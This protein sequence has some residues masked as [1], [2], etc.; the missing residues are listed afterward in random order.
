MISI[1][2]EKLKFRLENSQ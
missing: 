1:S 2:K